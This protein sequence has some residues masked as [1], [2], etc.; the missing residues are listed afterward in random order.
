MKHAYPP[1]KFHKVLTLSVAFMLSVISII[2]T[3]SMPANAAGGWQV[4]VTNNR[5]MT[6]PASYSLNLSHS[7][8]FF[9]DVYNPEKERRNVWGYNYSGGR[10]NNWVVTIDVTH[11]NTLTFT[12]SLYA[13]HDV[14]WAQGYWE[15]S[16]YIVNDRCEANY[17]SGSLTVSAPG[18]GSRT[19]CSISGD[20]GKDSSSKSSNG[21][22]TFD[23]S[24]MT[25]NV[26]FTVSDTVGCNTNGWQH[27]N[28]DTSYSVSVSSN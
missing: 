25:G 1:R 23:V 26:T 7:G 11:I 9:G 28:A 12:G 20:S 18:L 16:N 6:I 15:G 3:R 22:A 24:G 14:E 13:R 8:S 17:S 2:A 27:S 19:I 5:D 4:V 10:A 21:S